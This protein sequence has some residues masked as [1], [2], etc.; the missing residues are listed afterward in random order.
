MYWSTFDCVRM[1]FK[2]GTKDE[3]TDDDKALSI[4]K[5]C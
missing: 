1:Y 2:N 3:G 5:Y 4:R